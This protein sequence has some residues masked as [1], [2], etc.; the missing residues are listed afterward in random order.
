MLGIAACKKHNDRIDVAQL[1]H[2]STFHTNI[3]HE[4]SNAGVTI[5]VLIV[6]IMVIGTAIYL[7]MQH[8]KKNAKSADVIATSTFA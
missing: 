5:A 3:K 7:F 8:K 4:G 2:D 6:V 1:A